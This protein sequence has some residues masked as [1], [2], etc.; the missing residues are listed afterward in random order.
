[1][2][3]VAVETRDGKLLGFQ[4]AQLLVELLLAQL[5]QF[6]GEILQLGFRHA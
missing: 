5:V 4:D 6:I 2:T 1:M 3:F